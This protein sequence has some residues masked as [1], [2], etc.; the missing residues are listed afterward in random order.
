MFKFYTVLQI[1]G[2]IFLDLANIRRAE[3]KL[4]VASISNMQSPLKS[5]F[6][7]LLEYCCNS[8]CPS[9]VSSMV[10]TCKCSLPSLN[11]LTR[12]LAVHWCIAIDVIC[13]VGNS[14]FIQLV[15]SEQSSIFGALHKVTKSNV[16]GYQTLIS[17]WNTLQ[18]SYHIP[19]MEMHCHHDSKC[20][21]FS[22]QQLC[23]LWY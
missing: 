2:S 6:V 22:I 9:L 15:H 7:D 17:V 5:L 1:T 12:W 18:V 14:Q 3:G 19:R 21:M 11:D 16:L 10:S 20:P 13:A 23:C 4:M 8:C